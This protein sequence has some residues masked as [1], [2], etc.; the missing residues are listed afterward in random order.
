MVTVRGY[1]VT[2]LMSEDVTKPDFGITYMYIKSISKLGYANIY[3][4]ITYAQIKFLTIYTKKKK[5]FKEW[6]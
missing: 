4:Y 5:N 6:N 3:T 1:F 2:S